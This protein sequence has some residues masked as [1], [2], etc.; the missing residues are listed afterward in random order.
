MLLV[1]E[2]GVLVLD[3]HEPLPVAGLLAR[4]PREGVVEGVLAVEAPEERDRRLVEHVAV[5][6]VLDEAVDAG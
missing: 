4:D 2:D 6:D 5:E 1:L 3:E